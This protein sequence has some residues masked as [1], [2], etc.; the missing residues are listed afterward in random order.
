[1]YLLFACTKMLLNPNKPTTHGQL[2]LA[3][4]PSLGLSPQDIKP[5]AAF[6]CRLAYDKFKIHAPHCTSIHHF[7]CKNSKDFLWR[8]RAHPE[9]SPTA[10]GDT[11]SLTH[12]AVLSSFEPSVKMGICV[13]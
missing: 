13:E 4:R 9:T 3:S 1:M 10:G 7:Y 12:P 5:S 6:C 11:S 2:S 8:G